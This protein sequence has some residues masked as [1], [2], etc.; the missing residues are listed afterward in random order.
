MLKAKDLPKGKA[1]FPGGE[2]THQGLWLGLSMVF[3]ALLRSMKGSSAL[4]K[5]GYHT[6][7]GPRAVQL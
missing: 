4:L 7:W 2:Q 5:N 3:W 6:A 1:K